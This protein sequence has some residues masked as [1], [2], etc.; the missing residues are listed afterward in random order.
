[1][2]YVLTYSNNTSTVQEVRE[3]ILH[4]GDNGMKGIILAVVTSV[5]IVDRDDETVNE[6][7]K[8]VCNSD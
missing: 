8:G 7:L 1:L 5:R 3:F 4:V 2:I 6:Q